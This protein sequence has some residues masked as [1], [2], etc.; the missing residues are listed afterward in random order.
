[1][2]PS[3]FRAILLVILMG[4][5]AIQLGSKPQESMLFAD[6][7]VLCEKSRENIVHEL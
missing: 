4:V 7:L 5:L 1:M 6:D 3:R 2:L